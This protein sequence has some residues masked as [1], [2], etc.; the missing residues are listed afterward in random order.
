MPVEFNLIEDLRFRDSLQDLPYPQAVE[1]LD[2]LRQIQDADVAWDKF[3]KTYNWTRLP[4]DGPDT[5]PGANELH[6]FVVQ[7]ADTTHIQ[8]IGYRCDD[9]LVVCV[10]ARL[11]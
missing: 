6:S 3:A 2:V 9:I 5:Y 8:V 11:T 1:L 10:L 4:I 7:L